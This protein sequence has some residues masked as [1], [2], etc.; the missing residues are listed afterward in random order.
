[1]AEATIPESATP[2]LLSP[3]A[4]TISEATIPSEA[5]EENTTPELSTPKSTSVLATDTPLPV[6]SQSVITMTETSGISVSSTSL[7]STPT[8]T[9]QP[10]ITPDTSTAETTPEF[11]ITEAKIGT[12]KSGNTQ[13]SLPV[14]LNAAKLSPPVQE[15]IYFTVD[16]I[17]D[18]FSETTFWRTSV[19]DIN[20]P[21]PIITINHLQFSG[22][23][24]P[25]L[26]PDGK[27]LVYGIGY[28]D[29]THSMSVALL[30]IV[31]KTQEIIDKGAAP[32]ANSQAFVWAA[33]SQSFIYVKDFFES[34]SFE[35]HQYFLKARKTEQLLVETD[36]ISIVSWHGQ[37]IYYLPYE[38]SKFHKLKLLNLQTGKV[39]T[40]LQLKRALSS[41]IKT[42]PDSK[43][44]LFDG[45]VLVN[46][47]T[48]IQAQ[49]SPTFRLL[50]FPDS[51]GFLG[52]DSF[53]TIQFTETIPQLTNNILLTLRVSSDNE[54]VRWISWSPDGQYLIYLTDVSNNQRTAFLLNSL[55]GKT[56]AFKHS[57]GMVGWISR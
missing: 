42:S 7:P 25:A 20:N 45:G 17:D 51:T 35:I 48:K 38:F 55:S 43:Q 40:I 32:R 1:V 9:S 19:E 37:S 41:S 52:Q 12:D 46:L 14:T 4:T 8:S 6:A 50:W 2:E 26:S 22:P 13:L 33:D 16:D 29:R 11:Q 27:Y 30:D 53:A 3:T 49:I 18:D 31:N 44:V 39:E 28:S 10:E 5:I 21:T 34:D 56:E 24:N 36:L 15:I 54:S 47:E 57:I 23:E